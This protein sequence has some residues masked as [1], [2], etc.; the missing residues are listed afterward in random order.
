MQQMPIWRSFWWRPPCIAVNKFCEEQYPYPSTIQLI[1][2]K[3]LLHDTQFWT[4]CKN[5][6]SLSVGLLGA[7]SQSELEPAQFT[8]TPSAE[9]DDHRSAFDMQDTLKNCN[10]NRLHGPPDLL[11]E[12]PSEDFC[13]DLNAEDNLSTFNLNLLTQDHVEN[14]ESS[15]S[16]QYNP[17]PENL[18][19]FDLNFHSHDLTPSSFTPPLEGNSMTQDLLTSP[20]SVFLVEEDDEDGLT[21][22]LIDLLEDAAILNEI[23]L[24][25]L[26]PEEG[27]SPEMASR[28]E[29]EGYLDRDV[30]QPE[31]GGNDNHSGSSR[32]TTENR[33][34]G[35]FDKIFN[36]VPFYKECTKAK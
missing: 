15:P 33:G 35:N 9:L 10:M 16:T 8:L 30:A 27:F 12:D 21:S 5:S 34:Q 2:P 36:Y 19:S 4:Y 3:V 18:P 24:L 7:P 28:L 25:D 6:H 17:C 29:E 22:P 32:V 31:T 26:A 1:V 14:M 13:L 23:R 11:A 20:S